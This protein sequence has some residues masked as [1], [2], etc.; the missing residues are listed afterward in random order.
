MEKKQYVRPTIELVA[1]MTEG[2][3]L[4]I[5]LIDSDNS[6]GNIYDKDEQNPPP[7]DAKENTGWGD[8]WE[9]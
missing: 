2:N 9:E 4:D 3:L 7:P 5:S 6:G 8:L 1:T